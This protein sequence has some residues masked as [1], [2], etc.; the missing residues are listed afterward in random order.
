MDEA[1]INPLDPASTA[2]SELIAASDAYH[3]SLYP[4]ESIHRLPPAKLSQ[5]PGVFLGASVDDQLVGCGGYID[6]GGQ[7]GELKGMF[8]IP[9]ARGMGIGR[10]L[11]EALESHAKSAGLTLMRLETG[12]H[13]PEALRLYEQAGYRRRGPFGS[14]AEDP[15]SVFMEKYVGAQD[16]Y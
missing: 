14:Y 13:Q 6:C 8:V 12:I 1:R 16:S 15:L 2:A 5:A 10:R 3:A 11:L 4:P 7:Y 9:E